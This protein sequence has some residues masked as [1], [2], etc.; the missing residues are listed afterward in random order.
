MN[1]KMTIEQWEEE[2]SRRC[3]TE[4]N[5]E[6]AIA[7]AYYYNTPRYD[8]YFGLKKEVA[9]E[10]NTEGKP[11]DFFGSCPHVFIKHFMTSYHGREVV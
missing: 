10:K 7:A 9:N 11:K 4:L 6:N 2:E 5:T 1:L 3:E 8:F